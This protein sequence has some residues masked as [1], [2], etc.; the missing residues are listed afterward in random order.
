MSL[1]NTSGLGSVLAGLTTSKTQ[2]TKTALDGGTSFRD[3]M[4]AVDKF[5]TYQQ[6]TPAEKIRAS[7]LSAH[8]LT[9]D[10]IASM[11]PEDR[12]KVEDMILDEIKKQLEASGT[13]PNA[14]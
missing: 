12:Q 6:M 14:G 7:Y 1:F 4:S 2:P 3:N 10:D 13:K 5:M 8:G 11:S 9:E